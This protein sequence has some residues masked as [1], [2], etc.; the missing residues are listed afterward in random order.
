[1]PEYYKCIVRAIAL[2]DVRDFMINNKNYKLSEVVED[3]KQVFINAMIYYEVSM[4]Y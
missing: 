1:L 3:I 4:K 2:N